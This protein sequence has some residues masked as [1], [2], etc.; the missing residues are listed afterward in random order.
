MQ[1]KLPGS[2]PCSSGQLLDTSRQ[3]LDISGASTDGT[4]RLYRVP[5]TYVKQTRALH[6][7]L[8]STADAVAGVQTK[9]ENSA[10]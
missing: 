10:K 5:A 2:S 7:A 6:V 8:G 1:S 3:L 9:G 4:I